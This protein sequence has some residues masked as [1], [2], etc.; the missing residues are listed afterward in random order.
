MAVKKKIQDL[1]SRIAMLETIF[2]TPTNDVA[3]KERRDG[4]L[5]YV[6]ASPHLETVLNSSKQVQ[7]YRESTPVSV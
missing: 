3:E 7:G 1:C 5:R 4:L 6:V 2:A